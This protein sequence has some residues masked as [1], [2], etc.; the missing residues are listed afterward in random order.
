MWELPF[1]K[2][3]SGSSEEISVSMTGVHLMRRFS[4]RPL[5]PKIHLINAIVNP[6]CQGL[7]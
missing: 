1:V 5:P 7:R 6:T 2:W 4:S 3:W